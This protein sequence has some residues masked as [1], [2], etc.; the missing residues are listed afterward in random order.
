MAKNEAAC[1]VERHIRGPRRLPENGDNVSRFAGASQAWVAD[2]VSVTLSQT[3]RATS[4]T[5]ST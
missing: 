3:S 1:L 2:S 4:S 5:K